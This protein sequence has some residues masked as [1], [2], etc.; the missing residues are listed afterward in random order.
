MKILLKKFFM[1]EEGL[2]TVEYAIISGLIV[3]AIIATLTSI[4]T[5]VNTR[6]GQL[7]TALSS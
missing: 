6:F 4:G 2:E 5:W 3:V 7:L 1:A